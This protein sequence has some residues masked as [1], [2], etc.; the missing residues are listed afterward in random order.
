MYQAVFNNDLSGGYNHKA[1]QFFANF[2]F[3]KEPPPIK[4]FTPQFS[5]RC[6]DLQQAKCDEMENMG[7]LVDPKLHNIP[8][9]HV[10]PSWIQQKARAKN[11]KLE[12]C[13][14]EELRFITAFNS[15]NESMKPKCSTSCS[16]SQIFT[17]LARFRYF[18]FADLNNSYFQLPVEKK[19][20]GYLAIKT[21]HKGIR[22]MTRTGQGLLGSDI[23]LEELLHRVLG[24]P[25]SKGKCMTIRDDVLVGGNSIDEAIDNYQE[26]VRILHDNNLKLT[27][28]KV[29]LF[30]SDRN[31][32]L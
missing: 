32:W 31:L 4:V 16:S 7:V 15:L 18:I 11:K 27:P 22:V 29:R 12:D 24:E 1:G 8:I 14:L 10:S 23:K 3:K 28:S 9:L 30:P 20:W 17:F 26:V 6:Q 5:R 25:K 13:K 19:L 21:P 2:E